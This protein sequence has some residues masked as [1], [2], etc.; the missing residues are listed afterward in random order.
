[1]GGSGSFTN[2]GMLAKTAGSGT[3]VIGLSMTNAAGTVEADSGT[4]DVQKAISGSGGS[5]NVKT[6]PPWSWT[7]R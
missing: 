6:A 5:L 1:M 7:A 3:S 4:L 2:S